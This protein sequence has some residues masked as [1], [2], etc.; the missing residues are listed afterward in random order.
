MQCQGSLGNVGEPLVSLSD[1]RLGGPGDH[2]PWRGLGAST[3]SRARQGHHAHTEVGKVSG[4]ERRAKRPE[5]GMVA[6]CA[7]QRPDAGGEPR[8]TGL[9]GGTARPGLTVRGRERRERP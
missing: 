1:S 8:P 2:R 9:T 6:V 3:K 4:R 7:E 5:T